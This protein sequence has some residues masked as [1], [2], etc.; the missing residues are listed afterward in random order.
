MTHPSPDPIPRPVLVS[1]IGPATGS[2]EERTSRRKTV[3]LLLF[4]LFNCVGGWLS[5]IFEEVRTF[6]GFRVSCW[7]LLY[8]CFVLRNGRIEIWYLLRA[9]IGFIFGDIDYGRIIVRLN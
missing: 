9:T 6:W 1:L 8:S 5:M 7:A 2:G 4:V 3:R